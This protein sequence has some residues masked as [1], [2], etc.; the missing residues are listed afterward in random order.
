[1]YDD[2]VI[3]IS[4]R[5]R[6]AQTCLFAFSLL[7]AS[8]V[9]A[10]DVRLQNS[11]KK[12][13]FVSEIWE[14]N[15]TDSRNNP[16]RR[17][18]E[19]P[20]TGDEL[21]VRYRIHYAAES[22][23][24]PAD[25]EGEFFVLW[26]DQAEG[27]DG[28]THS[29]N[30]PNVGLHVDGEQNRFMIRFS[31]A[32]QKFAGEVTGRKE[33]LL[34]A[35]LWKSRPGA[36]LPFDQLDLW[37]D[38]S[39]EELRRPHV[40]AAS[41]KAI[42]VV[43]WIGFSTGAK[44][45][46]EDRIRVRDLALAT[47]WNRIMGLP[48]ETTPTPPGKIVRTVDFDAHVVPILKDRCFG[49][50]AGED[51]EIRL[52]VY[53]EVL[54]RTVPF[55]AS[56]STLIQAIESGKMPPDEEP[57]LDADQQKVLRAWVNE[58][59]TWNEAT[60]PTPVP[61]SDHWAFQPIVRPDIP[62]VTGKDWIRTP[63]D[64]FIAAEQERIG[65]EPAPEASPSVLTRR[66]SLD[67]L[68]LPASGDAA[69]PESLMDDPAFGV[70]WARHWLDVA[71][72]A[73]SNGHQHNRFRPAAWRYR[74]WVVDAFN[75]NMPFDEFLRAQIAGDELAPATGDPDGRLIATG[76]L[77]AA[78]YSG[79]ELDKRIQRNDIL[80]DVVNTTASA[81][82]GLTLECA[83]CHSHKF[84][85]ISMRDYYRMQAFFVGGQ[86]GN[87]SLS[88][89]EASAR[90]LADQRQAIFD[91]TYARLV[92]VRE[93]R[94]LPNAS[95]VTPSTVI[96]G[97][98]STDRGR[99]GTLEKEL[100]SF[101]QTWAFYAPSTARHARTVLPQEMRWPL[102]NAPRTLEDVECRLLLRGDV[103][104]PGPQVYPGWPR[105]FGDSQPGTHPRTA[106]VD[107]MTG[108]NNP[109]TARVWV[110]RI[111]QWH[112]GRGLVSTSSDFGT[113]G[114][115]P[116]HPRLLD[117]LAS[118]L[119]SHNWDSRHI[120]L[121]I[122]NSATYRQSSRFSKH[123]EERDPDNLTWWRWEPRRLEAEAVRDC[124]LAVSGQLDRKRGG[125]SETDSG[126]SV[127][128][129]L[130]LRQ[131]RERL[132]EQQ[133]LFDGSNAVVSCTLRRVSTSP[134]Q[135]L[136]LM[137]SSFTQT[138]AQKMA[139]RFEKVNEAFLECLGRQPTLEE[140]DLLSEHTMNHGAASTMLILLN[141]SEFLY[142][143]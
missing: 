7:L 137:N 40:S 74:D 84:D 57:S 21:F 31:S 140:S 46:V 62:I 9:S 135:P 123:N 43:N 59:V 75:N 33:R 82:L 26:L 50:H 63:V 79:N 20:F 35:R 16:L 39:P 81:F 99:F 29:G 103:N 106:L 3:Q 4:S 139:D 93:R 72:W 109:L 97:I 61:D 6:C 14:I 104:A 2:S 110:N 142:I 48:S 120:H 114:A 36:Q 83:Q 108:A 41:P 115:K 112:F 70:R 87:V 15:G 12:N 47:S 28:S 88:E 127:R 30:V 71:R 77:S 130:Y 118:E 67:L 98:S 73:E 102:P 42:S 52:D 143:P 60:L 34:V 89:A 66:W 78:R 117:F 91:Q 8:G 10:E 80:V 19:S 113:Q 58:G 94:G 100:K 136:W 13:A 51:A 138:A 18:L 86:P 1:M 11:W 141:T 53:D 92:R 129:S 132:P 65:I 124:I 76:F 90:P 17:Q 25:D 128:R 116:S 68:G 23:D 22:L 64:H 55:Q 105:V 38:P 133:N 32:S 126:K 107:W 121:L 101:P 37:V 122:L 5:F 54:N 45:E 134:L 69:D 44:T 49:C 111:W 95:L 131:H 119:I 125:P 27:N 56:A 24:T 85:P 96:K